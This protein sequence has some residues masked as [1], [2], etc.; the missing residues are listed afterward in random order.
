MSYGNNGNGVDAVMPMMPMNYGYGNMGGWGGDG[1]AWWVLLLLLAWGNN[2]NGFFG[3]GNNNMTPWLLAQNTDNGVQNG[4]NQAATSA[5]LGDILAAISNGFATAEVANCDRAMNNMQLNYQNQIAS[6]QQSFA[7]QT[8][9]DNHLDNLSSQLATCCCE[10]RENVTAAVTS[11]SNLIN[12][13][14]QR[15]A[16]QMCNDKI[17]AKNEK[18]AELQRELQMADLRASQVDQTARILADN[19]AQTVQLE[20]YL[21]PPIRPAYVVP[22]P[23]TPWNWG[24]WNNGGC[25]GNYNFN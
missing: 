15:I 25:C 12:S 24:N 21:D 2:G 7:E 6:M 17:D 14:I 22:N 13:G 9:L 10:N 5:Q 4:F 16:D 20:N 18:I 8:N 1:G 19:A 23:N 11:L 3:G